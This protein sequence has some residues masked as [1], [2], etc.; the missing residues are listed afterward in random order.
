MVYLLIFHDRTGRYISDFFFS[1][2]TATKYMHDVVKTNKGWRLFRVIEY[3]DVAE[4]SK[5]IDISTYS[6]GFP[7]RY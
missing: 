7:N 4:F 1:I 5:S 2:A 6:M 3:K